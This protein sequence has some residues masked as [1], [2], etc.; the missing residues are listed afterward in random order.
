MGE[1]QDRQ[2]ARGLRGGKP[3]AWAALYTAYFPRVW[4]LVAR[5]IGR[6]ATAVAD[7]VQETFLAAAGS[8]GRFDPG[9]GSLWLWLGGI[10]RNHV[11]A[12]HRRRWRDDR[13]KAGGDL[14]DDAGEHQASRTFEQWA[15]P[16]AA[17]DCAE[18][19]ASVRSALA[20]LPVDYQFLLTSR[21]CD[22]VPVA[23]LAA[24][25]ASSEVAVRS[26]LARARRA[27]REIFAR[28][29]GSK[30]GDAGADDE[31]E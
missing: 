18:R 30:D 27:F 1:D 8:A 13:V 16:P 6:D 12:H 29:A 21:Y 17:C 24:E 20:R 9:R 26:K 5:R 2:I 25:Q 15:D 19:A 22:D 4:R 3:E 31:R 7:V 14:H 11:G 28:T 23:Q 10:A